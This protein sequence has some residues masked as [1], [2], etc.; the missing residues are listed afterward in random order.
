MAI[1]PHNRIKKRYQQELAHTTVTVP[2]ACCLSTVGEDGYPNTRVVSLKAV[3][4]EAFVIT[5]AINARKG[6]EIT[7]HPKVA[8]NFWWPTISKQVRVQGL[9]TLLSTEEADTY[10]RERE[11]EAQIVSHI[12][13]QGQPLESLEVLQQ[14]FIA[15]KEM[16]QH[17]TIPRP[18]KWSGF[19]ITPV[20]IE[21]MVFQMNRL[22]HREIFIKSSPT[23]TWEAT[24]L[25]P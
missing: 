25:Q 8:L 12:T 15:A 10:F 7:A 22:H 23:E 3:K 24:L 18:A 20:R 6:K 13:Q 1:N 4:E 2:T 9:A 21:F 16:F 5:G 17:R 14:K 19:L 11:K